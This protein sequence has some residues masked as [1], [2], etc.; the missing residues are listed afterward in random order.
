MKGIIFH[1]LEDVVVDTYG[2]ATWD[3]LLDAAGLDGVYTS[4]GSY[5]DAEI[6]ALVSA[7]AAKLALPEGEVLRWCVNSIQAHTVPISR[8][9]RLR[10]GH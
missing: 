5:D 1:L 9:P 6:M 3:E 7:A 4:L 10:M 8:S 2:E